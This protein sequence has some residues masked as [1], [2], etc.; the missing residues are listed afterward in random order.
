M[1]INFSWVNNRN[2][3]KS[4]LRNY[5]DSDACIELCWWLYTEV[6]GEGI[7]LNEIINSLK[8]VKNGIKREFRGDLM[9]LHF[10]QDKVVMENPLLGKKYEYNITEFDTAISNW[11]SHISG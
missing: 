11:K 4:Q 10:Y 9:R 2:L 1:N 8:E 7:V 6:V 5:C 3:D